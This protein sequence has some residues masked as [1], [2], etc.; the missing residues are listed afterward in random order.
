VTFGGFVFDADTRELRRGG[1]VVSLSPKAFQLL[2]LLV[3]RRPKALSRTDLQEYLWPATFVVEKNLTNLVAEIREAL[4][5]DASD[6]QFVRTVRRFGYA[7]QAAPA[8]AA[9]GDP[10][11]I[12]LCLKGRHAWNRR[13][14]AGLREAVAHLD[15]A[16]AR[17]PLFVDA[18]AGLADAYSLMSHY[19]DVSPREAFPRAKAAALRALELDPDRGDAHTSL[20][21]IAHRFDWNW[22][23]AEQ[24]YTRALALNPGYATA[25]HW[26][27]EFLIASG[28]LDAARAELE[29]A[30]RLDPLSPRIALDVSLPDYFAGEYS[31]AIE[32]AR[33]I[34]KL[35][36]NF[37]P[38][39]IA[40]RQY[41]EREGLY[42]DAI[43]ALR[44][45]GVALGLGGA[46]AD[47]VEAAY[48]A[49]GRDGY[50]RQLIELA[51]RGW[52]TPAGPAQC[53]NMHAALGDTDRALAGLDRA[54][55][56]HDDE[57]VWIAVEP[58]YESLRGEARFKDLVDR[59]G[60]RVP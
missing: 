41:C 53:A 38:A 36:P 34:T 55:A 4:G 59:L 32:R 17:D 48:R 8:P 56:E 37:A 9:A 57:I 13:T 24:A 35:H 46:E 47:G 42:G 5:D 15:W 1:T 2:A 20:A 51:D 45:S 22:N 31:R 28:R 26:Y 27:G 54:F 60:Q 33:Q 14:A 3:E 40:L 7:F 49:S 6:P 21:Y 18:Y 23:A 10:E 29:V 19:D 52:P 50:W 16:L 58:W 12:V 25:H 44:A 39:W 43:A 11:A 30:Q